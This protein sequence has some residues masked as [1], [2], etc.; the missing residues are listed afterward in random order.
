MSMHLT[1]KA[2][3][4]TQAAPEAADSACARARRR[5][6]SMAKK[7]DERYASAQDFG[8]AGARRIGYRLSR[9]NWPSVTRAGGFRRFRA[10]AGAPPARRG[11]S[12][13]SRRA[14]EAG[15][16]W[17]RAFIARCAVAGGVGAGDRRLCRGA[18]TDRAAGA[19]RHRPS[20]SARVEEHCWRAASSSRRAPRCS[21][22]SRRIPTRRACTICSAIST[23]RKASASARWPTIT[24]RSTSTPPTP[25][26]RSCAATCALLVAAAMPK[27]TPRSRCSPTTSASRRSPSWSRCAKSC[28]DERTRKS[29]RRGRR[30]ARRRRAVADAEG[31]PAGDADAR[32]RSTSCAP[33]AAAASAKRPRSELIAERRQALHRQLARGP[34]PPRRRLLGPRRKPTAA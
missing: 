21:S 13:W 32:S 31:Q 4:V 3:P 1:Q 29:A 28:R 18:Q 14:R 30:Q 24:T 10:S 34:R 11:W 6:R 2:M 15:V 20:R 27:A 33:D 16:P 5:A 17:P 12:F 19:A 23:T 9:R 26:T 25:P 7:R 8:A 22:S